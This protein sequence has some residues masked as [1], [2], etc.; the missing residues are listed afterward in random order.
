[1]TLAWLDQT[2]AE[3]IAPERRLSVSQWADENRILPATSA[4]PG[5]RRT[6]RA[7]YLAEIMDA[8]S[9]GSPYE[10]VV[11]MKGA[12]LG[13]TEAGFTTAERRSTT[14]LLGPRPSSGN[15]RHGV[16]TDLAFAEI[17]IASDQ[18]QLAAREASGPKP[19]D[20]ACV[21]SDMQT[22][23][24]SAG[25]SMRAAPFPFRLIMVPSEKPAATGSAD[26]SCRH[27]DASAP[28]PRSRSCCA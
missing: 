28:V 22:M 14:C 1:M 25:S 13:A 12:Q 23:L 3:A 16:E 8:L 6:S 26:R 27:A 18:R 24:T 11:L 9:T 2:W 5:Q 15:A 10:C 20:R 17:G 7:P 21:T 19:C 4:E